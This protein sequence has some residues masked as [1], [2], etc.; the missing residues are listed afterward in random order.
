MNLLI[1]GEKNGKGKEYN[2]E[3]DIVFDGEYLN[4]KKWNYYKSKNKRNGKGKEYNL[5]KLIFEGKYSDDMRN[6][7]GIEYDDK[8]I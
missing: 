6:G 1:N 3:G 8:K 4:E 7:K 5:K 2:I